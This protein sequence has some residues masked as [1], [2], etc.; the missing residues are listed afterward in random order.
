MPPLLVGWIVATLSHQP[1]NWIHWFVSSSDPWAIAIFIAVLAY[2]IFGV[3]SLSQWLCSYGF[4]SLAQKVQHD[5]R[6]KTYR[7]VQD[8]EMKFFEQHRLGETLAMLNDDIN[9]MERFLNTGFN[10]LLQLATLLCFATYVLFSNSWQLALVGMSTIP[11]ILVGSFYFQKLL[12]PRYSAMRDALG[13]L[14]A[15]LENNLSGIA[16]IKSF[17]AEQFENKRMEQASLQYAKSNHHANKL[18]TLFI[19]AIRMVIAISFSGV[20]LIGSYWVLNG[21]NQ[22]TLAQLVLFSM[23]IQRVLWPLTSLGQTLDNFQR[24]NA[25]AKRTFALL[26]AKSLIQD[27]DQPENFEHITG[28]ITFDDVHFAYLPEQPILNGL[29]LSI[30]PQKTVGVVGAT[31]AGKTTLIKLLLRLY[32]VNQGYIAIDGM[33]IRSVRIRDLRKQIAL[34]SQDVYLFHGSIYDNIAYGLP[35]VTPSQVEHA[36]KVAHL[37]DF[38]MSLPQN[39]QTLVGERGIKLSGGQR[40]RL[41]IARAILKNAR[42]MIFDEAT[43]AVDTETEKTIQANLDD[44]TRDKTA[45]IIAHR[46]STIR[47]AD[48]IAVLKHGQLVESGSHD[49]LI[50]RQGAYYDLWCVQTGGNH[51]I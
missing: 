16:V 2:A 5:L 14:T 3:E 4:M 22:L 39:Y 35:E 15:R 50:K 32:D 26:D 6:I 12:G 13:K 23:L 9:Q 8:R 47:H 21:E 41:S 30:Q 10:E 24:A 36:A 33:D 11:F 44:I 29:N 25:S 45:L 28:E 37:H 49:E 7:H 51:T 27:P 43:S 48:M 20:L 18:S 40:Q 1:P 34:V 17:T 46:L 42:I 31:G 38:I 19:P